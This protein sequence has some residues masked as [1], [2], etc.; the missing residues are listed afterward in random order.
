ME[1]LKSK[2]EGGRPMELKSICETRWCCQ[3]EAC[4]ALIHTMESV[5]ATL[6]FFSNSHDGK[7]TVTATSL[8]HVLTGRFVVTLFVCHKILKATAILSNALQTVNIIYSDAVDL[9]K[10]TMSTFH[11]ERQNCTQ[12]NEIWKGACEIID[13]H[14]LK[15]NRK[16]Q[17]VRN[18]PS[19]FV[20]Q[21]LTASV[22]SASSQQASLCSEDDFKFHLYFPVLDVLTNQ[23]KHRFSNESLGILCS[24]DGLSPKS[25]CFLDL[26]KLKPMVLAYR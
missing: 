25:E 1:I 5:L 26:D 2:P 18:L 23:L 13:R 22:P 7:R 24:L 11:D 12:W 21:L 20:T 9:I 17:R 8:S 10:A 19:K 3:H 4:H 15:F 6:E 14:N 16:P